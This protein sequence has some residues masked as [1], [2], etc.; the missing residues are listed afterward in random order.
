M[1]FAHQ[2]SGKINSAI[3]T[4]QDIYRVPTGT[5]KPGKPGKIGT[6]FPVREKS[7]NFEILSKVRE[8]SGNFV[9]NHRETLNFV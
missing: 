7:G 3:N 4:I 2:S 8:K 6:V 9:K 5:G 1:V